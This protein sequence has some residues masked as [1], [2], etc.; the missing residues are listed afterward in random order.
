MTSFTSL[1]RVSFH[2]DASVA[3]ENRSRILWF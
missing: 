3:L 2:P 1:T